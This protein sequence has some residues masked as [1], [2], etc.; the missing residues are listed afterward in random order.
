M[1][2]RALTLALALCLALSLTV[3]ALA[4]ESGCRVVRISDG[5]AMY[6]YSFTYANGGD[7]P[8]AVDCTIPDFS[9]TMAFNDA[10]QITALTIGSISTYT[11]SYDG[12]GNMTESLEEDVNEV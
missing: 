1:K 5:R 10:G 12:D 6:L 7:L 4:A 2:K 11:Y 9:Q 3:P 8:T